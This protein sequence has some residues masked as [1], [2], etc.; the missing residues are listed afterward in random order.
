MFGLDRD[1]A[2]ITAVVICVVA[3]AYLYRELKKSQEEIGQVK[4]FI[5]REVEESQAYMNAAA[6]SQMMVPSDQPD[7]NKIEIIEEEPVNVPEK[8]TTRSSEK[9]QA[10]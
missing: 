6:A 10:Q 2:I 3:S 9:I 4:S 5:E 7:A 8:R 1:T